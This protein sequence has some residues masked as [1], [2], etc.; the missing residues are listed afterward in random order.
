M[1][2]N[3]SK[4][5]NDMKI[6]SYNDLEKHF[7]LP[8]QSIFYKNNIKIPRKLKKKVKV[9]CSIFYKYLNNKQRLWFY[10]EEGNPEYKRFLIKSICQNT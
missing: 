9:F 3:S 6:Y 8:K 7:T 1:I 2:I 5:D 4:Y 10:L